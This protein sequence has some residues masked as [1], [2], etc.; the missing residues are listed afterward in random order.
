VKRHR[1][2]R[3]VRFLAAHG[4]RLLRQHYF[5]LI[6]AAVLVALSFL[7]LTSD[8]FENHKTTSHHVARSTQNESDAALALQPR[9]HRISVLFYL[10]QDAQQRDAIADAV[11]S[12]WLAF[13]RGTPPIDQIIYLIAG[14]KQEEAQTIDRLNFEELAAQQGGVDMRVI[15]VRG[16]FD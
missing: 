4:L 11:T 7:V 13:E 5:S 10:V 16:S 3:R 15:D 9:R 14:T 6:T 1:L 12:D 8:S 2:P